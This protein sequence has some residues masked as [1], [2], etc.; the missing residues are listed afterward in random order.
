MA[1]LNLLTDAECKAAEPKSKVYYLNDG[2]GLRLRI[3]PNGGRNWNQRAQL[4]GKEKN[5][6]LGTYP[7]VTLTIARSKAQTN[8]NLI[9]QNKDPVITKLTHRASL[10]QRSTESFGAIS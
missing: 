6:G 8:R 9:S 3:H 7:A 5:L 4:A 10:A 2:G 1:G